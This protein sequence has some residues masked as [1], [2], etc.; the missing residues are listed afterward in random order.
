MLPGDTL[1]QALDPEP[2]TCHAHTKISMF[3]INK[4][5]KKIHFIKVQPKKFFYMIKMQNFQG[6]NC[7]L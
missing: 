7:F 5:Q 3:F 6:F 1:V 4:K 2:C